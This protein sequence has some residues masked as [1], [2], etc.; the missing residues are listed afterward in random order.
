M[1]TDATPM[2][3]VEDKNRPEKLL[4][5]PRDTASADSATGGTIASHKHNN[6]SDKATSPPKPGTPG[7][8]VRS[9]ARRDPHADLQP[10]QADLVAQAALATSQGATV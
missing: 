4:A 1:F 9:R 10:D 5:R 2:N 6:S 8:P 7:S 3:E